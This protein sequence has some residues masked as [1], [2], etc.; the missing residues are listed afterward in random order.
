MDG[1]V[2]RSIS[3]IS[4]PT[5]ASPTGRGADAAAPVDFADASGVLPVADAI[6]VSSESGPLEASA[7]PDV[8]ASNDDESKSNGHHQH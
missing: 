7:P 4:A 5:L 2:P 6:A 8:A 3:V 1:E